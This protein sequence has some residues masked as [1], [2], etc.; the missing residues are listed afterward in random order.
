MARPQAIQAPAVAYSAQKKPEP[1]LVDECH[2]CRRE[3]AADKTRQAV[4]NRI[5]LTTPQTYLPA[6][7]SRFVPSNS[8]VLFWPSPPKERQRV[9][10][11]C[12]MRE[13]ER[14]SKTKGKK[15][16]MVIPSKDMDLWRSLASP[17]AWTSSPNVSSSLGLA[18][19]L[20]PKLADPYEAINS[21]WKH[22]RLLLAWV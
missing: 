16:G 6:P 3:T 10:E 7:L 4:D 8:S 13:R 22:R 21:Q 2:C 1:C 20:A 9:P 5:G 12:T 18:P 11:P 15:E 17:R 19:K 14:E